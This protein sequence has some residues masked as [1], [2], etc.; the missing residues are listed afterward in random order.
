MR[1]YEKST[2]PISTRDLTG[3]PDI[4]TL[5]K[6]TQSL[7]ILDSILC[8]EW[9]YRYFSFNARWDTALG[10]RMAS[11]RNGS[12]D[13][14]FLL[15]SARGAI[16]KG[17][18]HE[19]PMSTWSNESRA[20]WPGVLDNVPPEF[21]DFLKKPAFNMADTT[22]CIWRTPADSQWNRGVISFP[23]GHDPDG[24]EGLLWALG[25]NQQA[26]Q[27]FARDYFEMDV[28]WAAVCDVF[29]HAP[30]TTD[31]VRRLN[32]ERAY[33]DLATNGNE[34]GYPMA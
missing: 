7:A 19:S 30:L 6:I 26:Y 2:M 4:R 3:L 13:E 22:F 16:M 23:E 9:E 32:P 10:E 25:G 24:S 8:P 18:D 5:E 15:F 27:E 20:V 11:M 1:E 31:L 34:I 17:F 12:G 28:D 33:A 21:A 14:Y 29:D